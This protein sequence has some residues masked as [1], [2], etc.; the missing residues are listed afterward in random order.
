MRE[1]KVRRFLYKTVRIN[2]MVEIDYYENVREKLKLGPLYVPHHKKVFQLMK[3]FWNEEQIKILSHFDGADSYISL[4]E[5]VKRTNQ[6]KEYLREMLENLHQKGTISKKGTKYGLA[7]LLPGVFE[8][9]FINRADSE[10]NLKKA[11]EVYRW[12]FKNFMPSFYMNSDFKLFRPRLP[13][14]AEEKLIEIDQSLDVESKILPYELITQLIDMYDA[15]S[16]IPCQCR[17]I[18]E[19]TG[20]PC[21]H[22]PADLGCFLAGEGAKGAIEAGLP[23]LNKEQ[24]IEY[25]RKTEKA[26]LIHNCIADDSLE[27]TLFVCNCCSC[28]CGGLIAG[29]EHGY[30]AAI[31][32]NY[33]PK[34]DEESCTKCGTCVKKC[35]MGAIYHIL[36]K[37]A[38]KSDEKMVIR[39]EKCLGCGVCATNCPNNAIKLVK[40]RD[41]IPTEKHMIG[42]KTFSDIVS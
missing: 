19:L 3:V 9:Y 6:P 12:L 11:A 37:L 17:L 8:H 26:G 22:A 16:Y 28:H 27:S 10:E 23:N 2:D 13:V 40:V 35:Q 34:I 29:K 21:E 36:P 5:L 25:L 41:N 15:F 18:G 31:V 32:S 33:L 24:A 39:E 7:P 38:D 1:G 42:N 4:R 30:T 14:D 20:E